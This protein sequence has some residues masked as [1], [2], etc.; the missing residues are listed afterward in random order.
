MVGWRP[1]Q[2]RRAG[3]IGSLLVA[4]PDPDGGGLR[5][6]GR[7]GT[8]FDDNALTQLAAMLKPIRRTTSPV[9]GSVPTVDARDAIWVRPTL[10]GEVTFAELT[11]DRRLRQA[12]WRGL[13]PDVSPKQVTV[14]A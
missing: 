1:G 2:G 14:E 11:A 6:A 13:R 8:G 5:Y 10:V 4:L 9:A 12:S 7:V 3:G